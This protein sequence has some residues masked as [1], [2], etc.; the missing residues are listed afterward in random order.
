MGVEERTYDSLL[1]M[2]VETGQW[3]IEHKGE[4]VPPEVRRQIIAVRQYLKP[5]LLL[6]G[7][8]KIAQ[9]IRQA[10]I[11]D[12]RAY[13]ESGEAEKEPY[14]LHVL[15]SELPEGSLGRQVAVGSVGCF[16]TQH[17][18]PGMCELCGVDAYPVAASKVEHMSLGQKK[19]FIKEFASVT[20]GI[21]RDDRL[22]RLLPNDDC[23]P[24]N[25]PDLLEMQKLAVELG[26]YPF[27]VTTSVPVGS[28]A[29]VKSFAEAIDANYFLERF[30]KAKDGLVAGATFPRV[31]IE[32]EPSSI[33]VQLMED[34]NFLGL[35]ALETKTLLAE[36]LK[37]A[38]LNSVPG[39]NTRHFRI[40]GMKRNADFVEELRSSVAFYVDVDNRDKPGED[41]WRYLGMNF[42][43]GD[44]EDEGQR[45]G[46]AGTC[47]MILGIFELS[48]EVSGVPSKEYP[49]GRLLVPFEGF[50]QQDS[51]LEEGASLAGALKNLIVLNSD[52]YTVAPFERDMVFVFDGVRLR[53][54][55]FD[56]IKYTVISDEVLIERPGS[57]AEI[58]SC[59]EGLWE[60]EVFLFELS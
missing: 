15:S 18:C 26:L 33:L 51:L 53:R 44:Y 9:A 60:K 49:Q 40:S 31:R 19:H 36:K 38:Y 55:C 48:S 54:I 11:D 52:L 56:R 34:W 3:L 50:V 25:D 4:P 47:G 24:G 59:V 42:K 45:E 10:L 21:S 30:N 1:K 7:D 2:G 8:V 41:E 16:V 39:L 17:G 35:V 57:F 37:W 46:I 20:L 28:E 14:A 13:D 29:V 58:V 32:M 27:Y 23:D 12:K 43:Q 6:S 22:A 5:I